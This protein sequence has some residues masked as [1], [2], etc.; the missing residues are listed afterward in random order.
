MQILPVIM[1]GGSGTRVWP[2]SRESLPKQFIPLVG[3]LSTFQMAIEV[4]FNDVSFN[5]PVVISNHA[6]RF[7]VGEQ[8]QKIGRTA[9]IVLEP[10]GRDSGPAVAVAAELALRMAPDTIVAVLAAD[11]VVRDKAGFVKLCREAAGGG[12]RRAHRDARR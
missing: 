11:H 6:Y 4:L 2:E 1:C 10:Q 3:E 9:H 5:M 8:L 12:A 7:L